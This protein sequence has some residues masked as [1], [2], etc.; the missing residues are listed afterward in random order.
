LT[1]LRPDVE[2]MYLMRMSIM[3]IMKLPILHCAVK[4]E[5]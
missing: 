5:T 2:L 1:N 4:L 3:M